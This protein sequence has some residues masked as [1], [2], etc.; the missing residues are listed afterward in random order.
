ME[1]SKKRRLVFTLDDKVNIVRELE[2]GKTQSDVCK[3]RKLTKSTVSTIWKNREQLIAAYEKQNGKIKK[4]RKSAC[5]DVDQALYKWF[6]QQRENNVPISGPILQIKA[7][8]FGKMLKDGENQFTCSASW[9]SR[10]K[11]RHNI[12]SGKV[13]GEAAAVSDDAVTDWLNNKWPNIKGNF[14]DN[15]IFNGD[16]TGLFF[17]LSPDK[18]LKFKGEKCVG[19]KLSK[20]RI[21]VFVCANLTGTEKRKLLVIGKSLKPRCFKNVKSLPVNYMANK[22]AWMTSEIFTTELRKW[23]LELCRQKRKILLLVDNCPAHPDI[24]NLRNIKLVFLPANTTSKLQPMDQGVIHSLKTHYR[25]LLVLKTI[26]C[27]ENKENTQVTLLE[28]INFIHKAWQKILPQ[29]ITNC[30][31]HAGFLENGVSDSGFQFDSDDDM[32][33]SEWLKVINCNKFKDNDLDDYVKIDE[34]ITT[35]E[36]LNENEIVREIKNSFERQ[37]VEENDDDADEDSESC[38]ES[39]TISAQEAL[40]NI[41]DVRGFLMSCDVSQTVLNC[42]AEVENCVEKLYWSTKYKQSKITDFFNKN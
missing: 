17:K 13:V 30:F 3:E 22:K 36:F 27:I 20:E 10:F 38:V 32:P 39:P 24:K 23:D 25:K 7:E 41:K 8:E 1:T 35:T 34:E 15:D 40:Q 28:A 6:V 29:T 31:R 5:D 37:N 16:E 14:S 12:C 42:F 18:T 21:T 4:I 11:K 19:G 33:L 9:I 2:N 26:S